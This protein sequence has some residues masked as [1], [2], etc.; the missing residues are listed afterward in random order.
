MTKIYRSIGLMSGTSMD[1]IDLAL[2]ER[3]GKDIIKQKGFAYKAYE[4]DF[5]T[6]LAKLIYDHPKLEEIKITEN[7]LTI[8]HADL[9]NEFLAKNKIDKSSI[10]II[11]FHGHTIFHNPEK[12]ITWQRDLFN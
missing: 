5:K 2:I 9:V 7:E 12:S 1:G 6:R 3:D 11:S 8:L 10:D 4:K